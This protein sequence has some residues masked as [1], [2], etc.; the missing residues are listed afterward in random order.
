MVD[1]AAEIELHLQSAGGQIWSASRGK[2]FSARNNLG[3]YRN[4]LVIQIL[5]LCEEQLG[6]SHGQLFVQIEL[7]IGVDKLTT[8]ARKS[9][10]SYHAEQVP[11]M[12][13]A[14]ARA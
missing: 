13:K 4:F 10:P 2:S 11:H 6:Q 1:I 3:K 8:V 12:D 14:D 5:F 9:L 7:L